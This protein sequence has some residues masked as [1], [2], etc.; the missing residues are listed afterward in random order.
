VTEFG[1]L[2]EDAFADLLR[3]HGIQPVCANAGRR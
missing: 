1:V 2:R 3:G